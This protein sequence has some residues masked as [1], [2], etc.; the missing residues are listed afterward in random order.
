MPNFK[1]I[2][3]YHLWIGLLVSITPY[4]H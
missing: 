3:M 2:G 1:K 4:S